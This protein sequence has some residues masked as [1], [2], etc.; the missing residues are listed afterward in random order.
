VD[1]KLALNKLINKG[2]LKQWTY[3]TGEFTVTGFSQTPV[4][5]EKDMSFMEIVDGKFKCK[6]HEDGVIRLLEPQEIKFVDGQTP[7]Q[8][9]DIYNL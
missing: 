2:I 4:M 6:Q 9:V 8:L 5:I 3:V 7:E 1:P